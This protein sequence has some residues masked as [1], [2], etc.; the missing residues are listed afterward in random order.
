MWRSRTATPPGKP[1]GQRPPA[2][3][4][5][6]TAPGT[7]YHQQQYQALMAENGIIPSNQA[8]AADLANRIA[9]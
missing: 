4:H 1:T 8:Q 6:P 3:A 9:C 2:L 7:P 5:R